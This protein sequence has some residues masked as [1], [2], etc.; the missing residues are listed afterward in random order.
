MSQSVPQTGI[1]ET[2]APIPLSRTWQRFEREARKGSF[3]SPRY[4]CRYFDWGQGPPLIF[5]H[6]LADRPQSFVPLMGHLADVFRCIAYELPN[7]EDDGARL[8]AIRLG[9]LA[10]DLIS[11]LDHLRIQQVSAYGA[12]FGG[13]IVLMAMYRHPRRF[14]RA[15]LQ[16][17]FARRPL[18]LME[19]IFAHLARSWS[20]RLGDLP[21]WS[22]RQ[23]RIDG[24]TFTGRD[25]MLFALKKSNAASVPI[26]A[27]AHRVLLVGKLDLR[28]ILPF[29]A[30]PVMLLTGDHDLVVNSRATD[31]LAEALPHAERLELAL[32]GHFAQ[33]THAAVVAESC[34]RFLMPPCGLPP[35]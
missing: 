28:P 3:D 20:G 7:G 10:D 31:E 23:E 15:M 18:A 16:S 35:R 14:L 21:L 17:S 32:C 29:I 13:T 2:A 5:V 27:F 6:G 22:A 30:H 9:D 24:P 26:R 4:H 11:L 25:P 19:R 12:S 33:Y 1:I 34:R 8:N